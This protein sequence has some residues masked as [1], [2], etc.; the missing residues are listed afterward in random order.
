MIRNPP[1]GKTESLQDD[2]WPVLI[3]WASGFS[4]QDN[5]II[6]QQQLAANTV[7]TKSKP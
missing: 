6:M 7:Q 3:K 4:A 2:I 5:Y 1:W